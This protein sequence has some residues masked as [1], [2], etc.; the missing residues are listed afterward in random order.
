MPGKQVAF[1]VDKFEG[2][3]P[4]E[5]NV[6]DIWYSLGLLGYS[7]DEQRTLLEPG[8]LFPIGYWQGN[9]STLAISLDGKKK[10]VYEFAEEDLRDNQSEGGDPLKS[11]RVV[12][13]DYA[14]LFKHI[15]A[16]KHGGKVTKAKDGSS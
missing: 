6:T 16:L 13:D 15:V 8:K 1:Q 7:N 11:A 10:A 5:D 14:D 3:T 2:S 9:D 4:R 12:Y